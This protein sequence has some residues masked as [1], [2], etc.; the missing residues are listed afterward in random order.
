MITPLFSASSFRVY[1]R[2]RKFLN[3]WKQAAS[4]SKLGNRTKNFI[5]RGAS[6]TSLL[7]TTIEPS[8]NTFFYLYI[9]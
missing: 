8:I 2:S 3:H 9:R 4:M 7:P 5:S 1:S 6:K